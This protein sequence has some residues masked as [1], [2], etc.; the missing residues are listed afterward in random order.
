MYLIQTVEA[1]TATTATTTTA[2]TTTATATTTA[3]TGTATATTEAAETPLPPWMDKRFDSRVYDM[4]KE[5]KAKVYYE[6]NTDM[7]VTDRKTFDQD[8]QASLIAYTRSCDQFCKY[9]F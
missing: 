5:Q 3:G 7:K 2:T 8:R 1:T 6:L 4:M 9:V